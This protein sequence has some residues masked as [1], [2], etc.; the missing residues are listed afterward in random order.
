MPHRP[1]ERPRLRAGRG[2]RGFSLI[3]VLV[4]FVIMALT[5]SV[6][7]QIFGTGL[8]TTDTADAYLQ[9]GMLGQA[10]LALAADHPPLRAGQQQGRFEGTPFGWE[11]RIT[12]VDTVSLGL[13][14]AEGFAT[15]RV[16]VRVSWRAGR[17]ERELT[18]DTLRLQREAP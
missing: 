4:A 15:Y 7:F 6:L 17:G 16:T 12:P 1:A 13:P 9:A 2:R 5:L 10:R 8:R 18:L 11:Q 3:E 14:A